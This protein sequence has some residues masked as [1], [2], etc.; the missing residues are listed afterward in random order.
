MECSYENEFSRIKKQ[1][2]DSYV[3]KILGDLSILYKRSTGLW[4]ITYS[5]IQLLEAGCFDVYEKRISILNFIAEN[6][7][8]IY[9][10]NK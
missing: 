8:E 6:Q 10:K 3:Q 4:F 9:K 5:L 7:N 1:R 2:R